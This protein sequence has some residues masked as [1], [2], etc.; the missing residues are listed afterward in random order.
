VFVG[1]RMEG[2][3]LVRAG[4]GLSRFLR[5]RRGDVKIG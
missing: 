3:L 1:V 4:M 2:G 5:G